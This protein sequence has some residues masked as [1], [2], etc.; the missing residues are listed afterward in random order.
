[1]PACSQ[2]RSSVKIERTKH[3]CSPLHRL[4]PSSAEHAAP[5]AGGRRR[6]PG[7]VPAER[8]RQGPLGRGRSRAARQTAFLGDLARVFRARLCQQPVCSPA[9]RRLCFC[10]LDLLKRFACDNYRPYVIVG[11]AASK[12]AV[13]AHTHAVC[14]CLLC[15]FWAWLV[16]DI[17]C[18]CRTTSAT[19]DGSAW[20]FSPLLC[21]FIILFG[22]NLAEIG[23][24]CLLPQAVTWANVA[25]G[26]L[27][28]VRPNLKFRIKLKWPILRAICGYF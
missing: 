16:V 8:E 2:Q 22:V 15:V 21:L 4:R 5:A 10:F 27:A 11:S 12:I 18:G 28:K 9:T 14:R 19:P 3:P 23:D 13:S 17:A 26:F 1:M 25:F 7:P 20:V 6:D 24:F